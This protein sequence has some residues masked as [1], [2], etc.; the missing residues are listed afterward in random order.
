MGSFDTHL[1]TAIIPQCDLCVQRHKKCIPITTADTCEACTKKNI[2]CTI[3]GVKRQGTVEAAMGGPQ[4][5]YAGPL[6]G[7]KGPGDGGAGALNAGA[8]NGPSGGP[9]GAGPMGKGGGPL[10][11]ERG[12]LIVRPC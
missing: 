7:G 6:D 9:S 10:G 3:D 4:I 12:F 8:L 5:R 2:P 1:L 11:G